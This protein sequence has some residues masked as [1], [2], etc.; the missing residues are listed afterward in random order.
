MRGFVAVAALSVVACGA[1]SELD[2]PEIDDASALDV[3][4]VVTHDAA[5]KA[6]AGTDVDVPLSAFC[7]V[8]DAG[9]P[10]SVCTVNVTVGAMV[11][12]GGCYID[13]V[14]HQGDTGTVSYACNDPS[15]WAAATFGTQTFPGSVNGTVV[16]VCI[17]TTYPWEDG[18]ACGWARS[19]WA[20]SQ[21]I[22]GDVTTGV[23]TFTYDEQEVTGR[24]CDIPC[25][26]QA[27]ITVD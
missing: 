11:T 19:T 26:A 6:D 16:N 5:Y 10:A 12:Q 2:V 13:V 1:R 7:A 8:T 15:T 27:I 14:V 4:H 22:Y 21:R 25:T 23:L 18:A 3:A 20:S 17:G 9:P 24:S